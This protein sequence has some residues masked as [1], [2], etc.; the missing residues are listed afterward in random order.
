MINS[1]W[2]VEF[3][4]PIGQYIPTA[5]LRPPASNSFVHRF[6]EGKTDEGVADILSSLL[7]GGCPPN[8]L[9]MLR[10]KEDGQPRVREVPDSFLDLLP[11][12]KRP[13]I[14]SKGSF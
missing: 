3:R 4:E 5:G 14:Q 11:P 8:R 1:A 6:H 12:D 10:F 9:L 7:S 2:I 13:T